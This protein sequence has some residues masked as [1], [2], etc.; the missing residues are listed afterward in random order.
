[1]AAVVP[2]GEGAGLPFSLRIPEKLLARV[3]A[4]AKRTGNSRTNA[5]L[6]LLRFAL[7]QDEAEAAEAEQLEQQHKTKKSA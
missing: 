7:A 3:D 2:K 6:H 4:C 1:M 5:F